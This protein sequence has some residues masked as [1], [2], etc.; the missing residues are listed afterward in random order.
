M[1][2]LQT[3]YDL[4]IVNT[5]FTLQALC[6]LYFWS[7]VSEVEKTTFS[8][9]ALHNKNQKEPESRHDE[10]CETSFYPE[11]STSYEVSWGHKCTAQAADWC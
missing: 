5:R 9:G 4:N 11:S 8:F 7:E 1:F 6:I 10:A 3:T 2:R